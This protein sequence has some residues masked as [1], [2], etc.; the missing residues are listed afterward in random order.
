MARVGGIV[1]GID[2]ADRPL[3][4]AEL[5]RLESGVSVQ[6][7]RIAAEYPALAEPAAFDIV[8][9]CLL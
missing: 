4:V 5:H 6:Y 8:T 9:L 3:K 1:T 7:R 2:L